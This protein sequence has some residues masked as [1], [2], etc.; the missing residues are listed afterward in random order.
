[1]HRHHLQLRKHQPHP[2]R[3][4]ACELHRLGRTGAACTIPSCGT[5][6]GNVAVQPAH[7]KARSA[8]L[9]VEGVTREHICAAYHA[10]PLLPVAR[11][12]QRRRGVHGLPGG[13][14]AAAALLLLH[15]QEHDLHR[16][17]CIPL[18]R[19]ICRRLPGGEHS[20]R[21]HLGDIENHV[22][23]RWQ[24]ARKVR[25]GQVGEGVLRMQLRRRRLLPVGACGEQDVVRLCAQVLVE[26][27]AAPKS[28]QRHQ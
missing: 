12:A 25:E 24:Q 23:L 22:R 28:R 8:P 9:H 6:A 17:P 13:G 19:R 3:R 21:E 7:L 2:S 15:A 18:R 27:D 4:S 10:A 14:V 16:L 11:P 26:R 5:R 20:R 1:M